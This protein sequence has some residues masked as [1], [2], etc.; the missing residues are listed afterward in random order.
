DV[1]CKLAGC[2]NASTPWSVNTTCPK[3]SWAAPSAPTVGGAASPIVIAPK[4]TAM[5]NGRLPSVE[6]A[7]SVWS[8]CRWSG[9]KNSSRWCSS[10]SATSMPSPRSWPSISSSSPSPALRGRRRYVERPK[11]AP[12]NQFS[13]NLCR[14]RSIHWICDSTTEL[15][16]GELRLLDYFEEGV[17]QKQRLHQFE[18]YAIGVYGVPQALKNVCDQRREPKIPTF[19]V[20]NALLHAAVL[21]VPSLNVLE[22][23]LQERTFRHLVG[24]ASAG[25]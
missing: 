25:Q 8:A 16:A 22:Q 11:S 7:A 20:V 15:S 19:A 23:L 2:G 17:K 3:T 21:R 24:Y 14:Q 4:A 12:R 5:C 18:K 10:L 1:A 9:S 13:I 6:M